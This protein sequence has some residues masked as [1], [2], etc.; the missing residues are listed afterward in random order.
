MARCPTI[1]AARSL[2]HKNLKDVLDGLTETIKNKAISPVNLDD[3]T[4]LDKNFQCDTFTYRIANVLY[5]CSASVS[6]G[7]TAGAS[8]SQNMSAIFVIM[9][10]AAGTVSSV[11]TAEHNNV[12]EVYRALI[13]VSI[14]ATK[15]VIGFM[16]V[17]AGDIKGGWQNA[18]AESG[19]IDLAGAGSALNAVSLYSCGGTALSSGKSDTGDSLIS[20]L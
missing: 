16:V 20:G 15:A 5:A 11:K 12:D 7:L 17:K 1:T 14:P 13:D 4:A 9:I 2:G 18:T 8:V 10:D 3:N 19:S 6:L